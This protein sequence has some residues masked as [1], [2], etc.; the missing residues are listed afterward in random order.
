M[1]AHGFRTMQ[2]FTDEYKK[3]ITLIANLTHFYFKDALVLLDGQNDASFSN[4][5]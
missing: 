3:Q 2:E 4:I 1:S 5:Q